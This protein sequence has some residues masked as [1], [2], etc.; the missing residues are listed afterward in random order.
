[1][2]AE[3]LESVLVPQIMLYGFLGFEPTADG[4][5]A[6]WGNAAVTENLSGRK[7]GDILEGDV[8]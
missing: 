5:A 6:A 4:R 7:T 3:L 8:G 1:L 2:D